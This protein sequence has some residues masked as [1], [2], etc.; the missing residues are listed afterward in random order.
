M[1]T[2]DALTTRQSLPFDALIPAL[3]ALFAEGCEVP[4][5]HTH[6]ID[7]P[8]QTPGI[9]LIMP[10]WQP[11]GFLGI[12]TVNIFAD[13]ASRGLPGLFSTYLLYDATT[14]EPLAHIDGNEITSRRT[15][16]A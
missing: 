2:Y 1:K 5:R 9:V 12:K 15:V 3:E 7:V 4:L 8:Q 14:G 16:A 11:G 10:A 6:R 13:N